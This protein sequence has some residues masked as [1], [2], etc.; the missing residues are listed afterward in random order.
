MKSTDPPFM[1]T[2]M[3]E[4]W[5][6]GARND[7]LA[8]DLLEEFR[9]GRSTGWYW[10]QVL[11][12]IVIGC[13]REILNHRSVLLFAVLWSILS[14]SWVVLSWNA[15]VNTRAYGLMWQMDWPWSTLCSI[16]LSLA[17]SLTFIWSGMILYLIPRMGATRSFSALRLGRSLLQAL[18]MLFAISAVPYALS[19][20]LSSGHGH[21]IDWRTVTP[22]NAIADLRT[23]AMLERLFNLPILLYGLWGVAP[24]HWKRPEGMSE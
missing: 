9:C 19:L 3:L 22:L 23:W 18:P 4:H 12:A 20:M 21:G 10:R 24:P 16:A 14:P 7:A 11:A 1:A 8:G 15:E 5:A 2:W 17:T 13:S 6:F